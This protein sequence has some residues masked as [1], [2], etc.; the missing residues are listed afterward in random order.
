MRLALLIL[1][2][3]TFG[4]TNTPASSFKI[5][6]GRTS[7]TMPF[8]LVDN[9][10]FIDVKVN[11]QGPFHFI[12]D[13]GASG[14]IMRPTAQRLGLKIVNESQQSGVGENKVYSG[15]TSVR[16]LQVGDAHFF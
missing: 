8:R 1:L 2:L 9:R 11:G 4:C 6:G 7:F 13:T 14:T 3:A 5:D 12:L 16:E 10:V 15:E